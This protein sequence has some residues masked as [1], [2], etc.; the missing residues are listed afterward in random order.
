M[1][2]HQQAAFR[3]AYLLLSS[4]AEAEDVTQEAFIRAYTH[5]HQLDDERPFRPWLLRIVRNLAYNRHRSVK[6]YVA[7]VQ[8]FFQQ[9]RPSSTPL[10]HKYDQTEAAE[11]LWQAVKQLKPKAQEVIYLRYFLELSEQET[12]ETLAIPQGTVK[13]RTSRALKALRPII[14]SSYPSLKE[15]L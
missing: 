10:T 5:L 14:E 3:L 12:A 4:P 9:E 2:T 7:M 1:Q 15:M 13:S 11:A 8:R 6:R